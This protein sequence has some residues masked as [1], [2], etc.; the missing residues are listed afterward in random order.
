MPLS[1]KCMGVENAIPCGL[2][3]DSNFMLEFASR[4][5]N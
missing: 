4:L 1:E 3:G 5:K 2:Y